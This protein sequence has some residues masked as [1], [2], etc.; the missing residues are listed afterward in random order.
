MADTIINNTI[1]VTEF[2][3]A[4]ANGEIIC[5]KDGRHFLPTEVQIVENG[6]IRSSIVSMF[7]LFD[8][9]AAMQEEI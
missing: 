6:I 1:I 5:L 3:V 7:R 8:R 4:F 9:M 2:E